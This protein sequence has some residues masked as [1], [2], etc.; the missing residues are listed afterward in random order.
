MD[1]LKELDPTAAQDNLSVESSIHL[2]SSVIK[3]T[4]VS[5]DEEIFPFVLAGD[6]IVNDDK[7][8][9]GDIDFDIEDPKR[10]SWDELEVALDAIQ[11]ASLFRS[12]HGKK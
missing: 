9:P 10:S 6:N 11:H 5:T 4:S 2:D 1:H 3:T 7:L 8:Q 12:Q